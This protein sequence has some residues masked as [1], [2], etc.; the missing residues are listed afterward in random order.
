MN[1]KSNLFYKV[2][3]NLYVIAEPTDD[4][5]KQYSSDKYQKIIIY[6]VNSER[7][8]ISTCKVKRVIP[9]KDKNNKLYELWLAVLPQSNKTEITDEAIK[10]S[11]TEFDFSVINFMKG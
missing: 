11:V 7:T 9:V 6:G 10:E 5:R 8:Q 3:G 2:K 4:I 1:I